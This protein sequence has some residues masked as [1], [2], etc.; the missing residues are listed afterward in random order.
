MK[1]KK[2]EVTTVEEVEGNLDV[3]PQKF[4]MLDIKKMLPVIA[5]FHSELSE[6]ELN[7]PSDE[8]ENGLSLAITKLASA[9]TL[10]TKFHNDRRGK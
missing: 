8:R 2:K 4:S 10:L 5:T 3:V 7:L 6:Y 9:V 1:P